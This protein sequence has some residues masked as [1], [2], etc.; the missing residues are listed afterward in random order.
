MSSIV[1]IIDLNR[2]WHVIWAE[3][4]DQDSWDVHSSECFPEP[5]HHVS[6]GGKIENEWIGYVIGNYRRC[7]LATEPGCKGKG[8]YPVRASEED[9]NRCER[10]RCASWRSLLLPPHKC[11]WNS[12]SPPCCQG[13]IGH[14]RRRTSHS[15][16]IRTTGVALEIS[17][18]EFTLQ[19]PGM[20]WVYLSYWTRSL[21][22][23]DA[24]K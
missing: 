21:Y 13:W 6:S 4:N 23:L 15:Q 1:R 10:G 20:E 8:D 11:Q 9:R 22:M 7:V 3:A 24:T 2:Y 14:E 5:S 17:R 16:S 18:T 19:W 12:P